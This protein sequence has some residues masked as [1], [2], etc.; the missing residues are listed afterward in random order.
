M[1]SE[2]AVLA[3]LKNIYNPDNLK[4]NAFFRELMEQDPERWI[5]L[6]KISVIKAMKP[7]VNG[8]IN[9]LIRAAES[10]DGE[11]EINE[12]KTKLRNS[13]MPEEEE[14]ASAEEQVEKFEDHLMTVNKKSIYAKGFSEDSEPSRKDLGALFAPFGRV[15]HIKYRRDDEKKFKGSVFVEFENTDIAQSVVAKGIE[16][17]YVEM[18]SKEKYADQSFKHDNAHNGLAFVEYEGAGDMRV[19]AIK[20]LLSPLGVTVVHVYQKKG[21]GKGV[22]QL[23][24]LWVEEF[25]AKLD[26]NKLGELTFEA[27]DDEGRNACRDDKQQL[28]KRLKARSGG[29]GGRS[30]F[31]NNHRR[32]KQKTD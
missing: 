26:D 24:G 18:K 31:N 28:I 16:S 17:E 30:K 32:K 4:K 13:T 7:L 9:L 6:K 2:E 3:E 14:K 15:M 10:S 20:D 5:S 25:L 22:V 21:H 8:D 19:E 12:Q 29:R 27:A 11:F 1:S 23:E